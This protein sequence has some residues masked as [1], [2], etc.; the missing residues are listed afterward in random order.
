MKQWI[1]T[2]SVPIVTSAKTA[3]SA[4]KDAPFLDFVYDVSSK[5]KTFAQSWDQALSPT[6]ATTLLDN[7]GKLFALAVSP[8]QFASNMNKVIGT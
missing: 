5:A 1:D 7:I 8:Q 3:L 4:S 6:A 2:G